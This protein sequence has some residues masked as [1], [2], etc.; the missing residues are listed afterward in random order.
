MTSL[1]RQAVY[2]QVG[3]ETVEPRLN[4]LAR[5]SYIPDFRCQQA[6]IT[7][8]ENA[9]DHFLDDGN[10]SAAEE[11]QLA[12]FQEYF[13]LASH[14][15][16]H[17]GAYT[18][19][20]KAVVLRELMEGIIPQRVQVSGTLPFNFHKTEQL[21]WVF[22]NTAYYED[23]IRRQYV[24]RSQGFSVRIAKGVYY[25]VGAY[26]GTPVET[27]TRV[28]VDTGTFA[29]TTKH[30]YFAGPRQ[31]LRIRHDKIVSFMPYQDGIGLQRDATTAKPQIFVTGDGWF[32]HNLL[33]NVS[34]L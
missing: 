13:S 25:R 23:K 24:G 28:H 7:G 30:V 29:V 22:P 27:T 33:A 11:K 4:E 34:H 16:N 8:W 5:Q 18:K 19:F 32:T 6:L 26:Q 10:L 17:H 2:G 3:L 20:V 21:I 1:V 31:S 12:A 15:L 14:M 9:V